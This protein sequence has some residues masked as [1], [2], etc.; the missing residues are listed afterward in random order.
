MAATWGRP[1]A[2]GQRLGLGVACGFG[3]V[4]PGAEIL[5]ALF[6]PLQG[7]GQGDARLDGVGRVAGA[8]GFEFARIGGL[9]LGAVAAAVEALDD[10]GDADGAFDTRHVFGIVHGGGFEQHTVGKGAQEPAPRFGRQLFLRCVSV[11]SHVLEHDSE[12]GGGG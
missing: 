9:A 8:V 1:G 10:G 12:K 3:G 7:A 4:P 6:T 2:V 11:E 5:T